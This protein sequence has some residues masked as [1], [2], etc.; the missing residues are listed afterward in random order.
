[1]GKLR[2]KS[3]TDMISIGGR[4]NRSYAMSKRYGHGFGKGKG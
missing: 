1:M 3:S 2:L 4:S